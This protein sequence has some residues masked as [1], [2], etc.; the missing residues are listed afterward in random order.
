MQQEAL[1]SS[2][3]AGLNPTLWRVTMITIYIMYHDLS[4][5]TLSW[6]HNYLLQNQTPND[7]NMNMAQALPGIGGDAC[8][9][10]YTDMACGHKRIHAQGAHRQRKDQ[11]KV[12]SWW[13]QTLHESWHIFTLSASFSIFSSLIPSAKCFYEMSC[14]AAIVE[15]LLCEPWQGVWQRDYPFSQTHG[16][17]ICVLKSWYLGF[18]PQIYI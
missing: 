13:N 3:E 7:S 17:P 12:K 18:N 4:L 15:V 11:L 1:E 8:E 9:P 6:N 16:L 10:L 2:G 5:S 14:I